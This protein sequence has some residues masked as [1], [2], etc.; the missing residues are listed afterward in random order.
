MEYHRTE[1]HIENNE[2]V[3]YDGLNMY[4]FLSFIRGYHIYYRYWTPMLGDVVR[5]IAEPNNKHDPTAVATVRDNYI[6]GHVPREL[7]YIFTKFLSS[8]GTIHAKVTGGIID[9]GYGLEV[10]VEYMFNGH[11]LELQKLKE[12]LYPDL[13]FS[14]DAEPPAKKRVCTPWES[15]ESSS[16]TGEKKRSTPLTCRFDKYHSL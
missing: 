4:T 5:C 12:S 8:R 2:N 15:G 7:S 6:C 10:P 11:A 16:S 9:R 14:N 13:S 3:E 1:Q